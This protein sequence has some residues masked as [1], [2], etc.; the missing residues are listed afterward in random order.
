[1]VFG[2]ERPILDRTIT[3][4]CNDQ[5]KKAVEQIVQIQY[6]GFNSI[7]K[8]SEAI[9]TAIKRYLETLT[10]DSSDYPDLV[11]SRLDKIIEE[12]A[13]RLGLT[14]KEVINRMLKDNINR[15]IEEMIGHSF[16]GPLQRGQPEVERWIS[17]FVSKVLEKRVLM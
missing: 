14:K 17:H 8:R 6:S 11:D 2:D 15:D 12:A 7:N 1:M 10:D 4:K 16:D 5:I 13:R 3:F 9:R